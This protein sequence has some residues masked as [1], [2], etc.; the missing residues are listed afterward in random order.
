MPITL[1]LFELTIPLRVSFSHHHAT[2]THTRSVVVRAERNGIAG[3]GE[4][5]PRV[6]VTG[7]TIASCQA[8]FAQ[9]RASISEDV[10]GFI[11]IVIIACNLNTNPRAPHQTPYCR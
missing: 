5:C 7:E 9:W 10:D 6:Y 4:G 11:N 2:R 3:F 1:Q 8:F